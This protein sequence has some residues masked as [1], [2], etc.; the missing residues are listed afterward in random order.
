M[1]KRH[2]PARARELLHEL[3]GLGIIFLPYLL[4]V[5]ECF[6]CRR[7]ATKELE[8]LNVKRDG[9]L[10]F[11]CAQVLNDDLFLFVRVVLLLVPVIVDIDESGNVSR[12]GESEPERGVREL[13][14]GAGRHAAGEVAVEC[15]IWEP[16]SCGSRRT[17]G[18]SGCENFS[19]AKLAS[20]RPTG[21][22]DYASRA[23]AE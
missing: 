15:R 17:P 6:V 3:S 7:A 5:R 2:S 12:G 8:A 22:P 13:W 9:V 14:R 21:P 20:L 16:I 11:P 18:S 4:I 10:P 1:V 23:M 19:G